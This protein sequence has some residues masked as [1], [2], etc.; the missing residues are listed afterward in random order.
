MKRIWIE[1][2]SWL[3]SLNCTPNNCFQPINS[4]AYRLPA[5]FLL[6]VTNIKLAASVESLMK[7]AVLR[8]CPQENEMI[9]CP[10]RPV[11][12][13]RYSFLLRTAFWFSFY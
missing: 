3:G 13:L 6:L 8:L 12:N 4:L 10:L 9:A 11:F 1:R 5:H 7:A 2:V